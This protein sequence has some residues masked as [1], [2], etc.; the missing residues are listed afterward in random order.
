MLK[1]NRRQMVSGTEV[2][3]HLSAYLDKAAERGERVFVARN[4]RIEVVLMG[5]EDYERLSDYEE[6]V[7]HLVAAE[8]IE[9]RRNE[10]AVTDLE[11]LLSEEGFNPDELRKVDPE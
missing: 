7:E 3:R 10:P 1:L 9:A 11:R 6:I 8:L 4:N 2:A 5:I